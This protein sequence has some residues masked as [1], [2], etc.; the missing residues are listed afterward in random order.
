M[1]LHCIGG[2]CPARPEYPEWKRSAAAFRPHLDPL[3]RTSHFKIRDPD[4]IRWKSPS[5]SFSPARSSLKCYDSIMNL[6]PSKLANGRE[7]K[8]RMMCVLAAVRQISPLQCPAAT[9]LYTNLLSHGPNSLMHAGEGHRRGGFRSSRDRD[10]GGRVPW[11]HVLQVGWSPGARLES[12]LTS[13][14]YPVRYPFESDA[15]YI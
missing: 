13:D 10:G 11:P 6:T 12:S 4:P 3:A 15:Q 5:L 14:T 7:F 2:G 8:V 1:H 9:C